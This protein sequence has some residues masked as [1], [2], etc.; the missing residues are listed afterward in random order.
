[1][2]SNLHCKCV[3][4]LSINVLH[5]PSWVSPYENV[6]YNDINITVA[7]TRVSN[8][9]VHVSSSVLNKTTEEVYS[10]SPSLLIPAILLGALGFLLCWGA[11]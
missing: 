6:E 5:L 11:Y 8:V 9:V 3:A 1:M 10:F 2:L 7:K 4:V